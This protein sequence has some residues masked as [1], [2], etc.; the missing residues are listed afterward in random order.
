MDC[1]VCYGPGDASVESRPRPTPDD[2][3]VLVAVSRVQLSI[4]ECAI[5]TDTDIAFRETFY[6]RVSRG[7]ALA[8]GHEF[9]GVVTDASRCA[10]FSA[11]DRVY[12]PGKIACGRCPHCEADRANLCMQ[13]ET[14]GIHR[15]GALAEY[16]ALPAEPLATLPPE[17]S[18]A[19]GAAMQPLASSVVCVQE[20]DIRSGDVV[21][22]IGTGVMGFQ[23]GQ[24]ALQHGAGR[25]I[26]IDI[27]TDQLSLARERGMETID[28]TAAD[29]VERVTELTDGIGAD[30]VFE[31]VGGKQAHGTAGSDPLA[32]AHRMARP[33]GTVVQ[34][35]LITGDVELSPAELR[36]KSIRLVNP[37]MGRLARSPNI[38]SGELAVELV[39][40]GRVTVE[41]LVTHELEGL[42]SFERAVE[43]TMNKRQYGARG[44]AQLV[45]RS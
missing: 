4:T 32:Q 20:A 14:I 2:G 43:I 24:I 30:V 10:E 42:R 31:A 16:V 44:P 37:R 9:C 19:E 28:A 45:L 23:C 17:I 3:E 41:D 27:D 26:A 36:S 21:A 38:D 25:V 12:A 40:S 34:V 15:P 35:G 22:V 18:D 39:R 33:A 1:V 8:F 11:G 7:G 5:F 13:K 29:P 6:D